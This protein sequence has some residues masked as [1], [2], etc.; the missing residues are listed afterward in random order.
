MVNERK[1]LVEE[2]SKTSNSE[3][4]MLSTEQPYR[5]GNREAEAYFEPSFNRYTYYTTQPTNSVQTFHLH[6][7]HLVQGESFSHEHI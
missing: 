1:V 2:R 3:L 7:F 5:D 4:G 6:T